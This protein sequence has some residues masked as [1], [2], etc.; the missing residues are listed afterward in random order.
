MIDFAILY[1]SANDFRR[2][3]TSWLCLAVI[4]GRERRGVLSA[5]TR[6]E[7]LLDSARSRQPFTHFLSFPVSSDAV[8]LQFLQFKEAVVSV[9]ALVGK[10]H[11]PAAPHCQQ[12][13]VYSAM[14]F[15]ENHVFLSNITTLCSSSCCTAS[16]VLIIVVVAYFHF[17]K[18]TLRVTVWIFDTSC[19]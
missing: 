13:P 19:S 6:V 1:L 3:L 7:V 10:T 12:C 5:K 9:C 16:D 8:T 14:A 15:Y 18:I 11:L 4:Q 17:I 2:P